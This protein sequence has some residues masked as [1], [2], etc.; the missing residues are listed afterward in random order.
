GANATQVEVLVN[1]AR[2][3]GMLTVGLPSAASASSLMDKL[4]GL[5]TRAGTPKTMSAAEAEAA[6]KAAAAQPASGAAASSGGL[7]AKVK[8][9]FS[10][11]KPSAAAAAGSAD[12]GVLSSIVAKVKAG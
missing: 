7:T 3:Q 10:R 5:F 11:F 6:A 9:F 8:G 2:S 4:K 12:P 1:N